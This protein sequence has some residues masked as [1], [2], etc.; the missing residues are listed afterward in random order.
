MS[1]AARLRQLA[2]TL[3][4]LP[5]ET[6]NFG[7]SVAFEAL[8]EASEVLGEPQWAAFARGWAR[9]WATRATPYRELDCT[10]P[11]WAIVHLG[12]RFDDRLLIDAAVGLAEE[13]VSRPT[14]RGLFRTWR[15]SPLMLPYG[16]ATLPPSQ[17]ELVADPPAG[18][19]LDCL[20]FDP[21]FLTAV[22]RVAGRPDLLRIGID[23]ALAY[24]RVLQQPNGLFDHFILDGLSG[25]FGPGWGRGQGWALLGL[26]DA[27]AEI[28]ATADPELQ[29]DA[30]RLRLAADAL[31]AGMI[32]LQSADGHWPAVV[33]VPSS[34]VESST[35][36]F[37]AA[38]F[39]R[40]VSLGIADRPEVIE[41]ARRAADAVAASLDENGVL[42]EVSAAVMACT[43]PTHYEHVP[44][45]FTV[46]WG[47]GPA[48]LALSWADR[49]EREQ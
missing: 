22:G 14:L 7:D 17:A 18:A 49:W 43:E 48:L 30:D 27:V 10:A 25:S 42:T 28:E 33:D 6:W 2:D 36:A 31:I 45:G 47:Q 26:L 24:V 3:C 39:F 8:I 4:D 40:A 46:P 37:M 1:H 13:L 41:A 16:P 15:H 19:F 21:P 44:R 38:G 23:Q 5:Y 11:G 20:H 32:P 29:A 9:A 12:E 34:G 35:A